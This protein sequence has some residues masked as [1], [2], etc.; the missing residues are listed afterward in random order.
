[1]HLA[2]P[3]GMHASRHFTPLTALLT[4]ALTVGCGLSDSSADFGSGPTAPADFGATQGGVQDMSFARDVVDNGR[5]PPPE[6]FVVEAMFS[7]HD[8]PIDGEAC[9]TLLCLRAASGLAPDAHGEHSAWVQVGMSSTIDPDAFERPSLSVVAVVDVSGSMGWGYGG[10]YTPGALSKALLTELS[11]RLGEVD[12]F[13]IVTYGSESKVL[14][15]PLSASDQDRILNAIGSLQEAGSTNM[16]AG[17][18]LGYQVAADEVGKAEQVR[19]MLFTDVQPNVGATS[20]SEFERLTEEAADGGVGLTVFALGLGLN[21]DVLRGMSQIRNANAFSLTKQEHVPELME[22][23]WPWM[24][25]PIAYDLELRAVASEGFVVA[26]GYGFPE[27]TTRE[28]GLSVSTVFLSKRRGA[29]LLRFAAEGEAPLDALSTELSLQYH[30][31]DGERITESFTKSFAALSEEAPFEQDG[32]RKTVLLARLVSAMKDS[33]E[34]YATNQESAVA[35]MH[36]AHAQFEESLGDSESPEIE[37]ERA[38]SAELLRLMQEGA[39]QESF[40]G[41]F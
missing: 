7:E 18:R 22:D 40:Y 23:S 37:A 27:S 26:D 39:Q 35:T 2:Q 14:L 33:A 30:T 21:P 16:E 17:L 34:L 5:V 36:A 28:T 3:L 24:V 38:F 15:N 8:L 32:V 10:D 20:A 19:V 41:G 9:D 13:A 4:L 1:M 11:Q 31:T 25:S 29:L 12:R 6:A